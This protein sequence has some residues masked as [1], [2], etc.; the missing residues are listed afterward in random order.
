MTPGLISYSKKWMTGQGLK[1]TWR[2]RRGLLHKVMAG[3]PAEKFRSSDN[4]M[5]KTTAVLGEEEEE[6]KLLC[7]PG[8]A[9]GGREGLKRPA[10]HFAKVSVGRL[11][12]RR[13]R[14]KKRKKKPIFELFPQSFWLLRSL[15]KMAHK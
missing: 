6:E 7:S 8:K 12:E 2:V 9:L 4:E 15:A 10:A 5:R 13:K 3:A 14:R 11:G 1:L